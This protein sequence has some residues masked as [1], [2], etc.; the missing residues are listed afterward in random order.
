MPIQSHT[1]QNSTGFHARPAR[2]FAEAASGFPCTIRV[3]KGEKSVNGKSIL[4]MLTLGAKHMDVL[5]IETEGEMAEEALDKLGRIVN[6][7]F[8]E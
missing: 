4:G 6:Q 3:R 5:I 1:I 2:Q 8:V 7:V